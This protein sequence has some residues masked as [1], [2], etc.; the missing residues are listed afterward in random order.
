MGIQKRFGVL[1][2]VNRQGYRVFVGYCESCKTKHYIKIDEVRELCRE[3]LKW[4]MEEKKLW[5]RIKKR[6]RIKVPKVRLEWG[7]D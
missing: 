3:Y 2:Y 6:I 5:N 1:D 7:I 4:E